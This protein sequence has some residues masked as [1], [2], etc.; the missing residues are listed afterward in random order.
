MYIVRQVK[1][2]LE[3]NV[4]Q[5]D[6][7]K[8]LKDYT[9]TFV[10][11]QYIGNTLYQAYVNRPLYKKLF[12]Q[13]TLFDILSEMDLN[14][15]F[16]RIQTEGGRFEDILKKKKL[17]MAE[18]A[19]KI[20]TIMEDFKKKQS[21]VGANNVEYVLAAGKEF[22]DAVKF[23]KTETLEKVKLDSPEAAEA[24]VAASQLFGL[25][26]VFHYRIFMPLMNLA[27]YWEVKNTKKIL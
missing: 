27:K 23:L 7:L 1:Q 18:F 6:V 9:S 16:D 5:E 10:A 15:L 22:M 3:N 2:L 14:D 4:P 12:N 26:H 20:Q 13:I 21:L 24:D 25:K 19:E 17:T 8:Y 11:I